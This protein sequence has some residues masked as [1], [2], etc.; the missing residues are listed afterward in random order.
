MA[1][2]N[3]YAILI[4]IVVLAVAVPWVMR[5]RHPDQKP[6]AAYLVFVS[7]FLLTAALIFS[8]VTWLLALMDLGQLLARPL[9]AAAFLILVFVPAL[10]IATWQARKPP[11]RRPPPA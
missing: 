6:F 11:F 2:D 3:T 5:I 9:A 4:G 10:G 7:V 1:F 8:L